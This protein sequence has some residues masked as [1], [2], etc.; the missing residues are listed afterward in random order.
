VG[1][2]ALRRAVGRRGGAGF[3]AADPLQ[4]GGGAVVAAEGGEFFQVPHAAAGDGPA[5]SA[6]GHGAADQQQAG[7][8]D[9]VG[10]GVVAVFEES[11]VD[12][13]GAV[14]Q[15]DEDDPFS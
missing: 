15:A 7:V 9:A 8:E 1:Q 5:R 4:R 14:L 10:A 3:V 13:A 2:G 6:L 12:Q 11:D